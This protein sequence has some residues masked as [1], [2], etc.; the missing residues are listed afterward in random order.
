MLNLPQVP[1]DN[2]HKFQAIAGL[3]ASLVIVGFLLWMGDLGSVRFREDC[4]ELRERGLRL[5]MWALDNL[6]DSP[7][8]K[9]L[10]KSRQ[11]YAN[12]FVKKDADSLIALTNSTRVS[13]I[14]LIAGGFFLLAAWRWMVKG[15]EQWKVHH[16]RMIDLEFEK[17]RLEVE[18]IKQTAA[19]HKS[20]GSI[21]SATATGG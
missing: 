12:L 7:D 20:M 9:E 4:R 14:G 15:F 1:T 11:E 2:L 18:A 10:R 5:Q 6:G 8:A 17:L 16:D 3:V 19:S 21:D 13:T